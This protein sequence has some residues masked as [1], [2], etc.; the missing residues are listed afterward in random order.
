MKILFVSQYFWPETFKG[1]DIVFE[2]AKKGHEITV[3]TAKPNYPEGNFYEGYGFFK[4]NEEI[5][6][7]VRIIRTPIIPR[8][9][10]NAIHLA[11]NYFSFVFFSFIIFLF[12]L[13]NNYDIILVQQ[14]SPIFS[15][16]PGV[17]MKKKY[18][19]PMVLWVLDLWPESI[20]AASNFKSGILLDWI[21]SIVKKVYSSSD[22]ILISSR[23]FEKSIKEKVKKNIDITYFPNWAEDLF[24]NKNGVLTNISG[25]SSGFN[26]MFA[27]NVGESQDFESILKA[28]KI[29]ETAGVNWIIIG[30]G[31]KTSWV[32][33]EIKEKQLSNVYLLGRHPI[34]MMPS[35]FKKADVMLVSLKDEPIFS[36]TV[37]AKIQAY[38]ASGKIILGMLNGEGAELIKISKCGFSV[39]AGNFIQLA[40]KAIFLASLSSQE[41]KIFEKNALS[42]YNDFFD[43]KM[44]FDQLERI[45]KS[46]KH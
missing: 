2:L 11:L 15:A 35:F 33:Q 12:K 37:P 20:S 41:K 4:P 1:N 32:K 22:H 9:N 46:V 16:L 43:K 29:T 36:L 25:L 28:A 7:G 45:L 10:G 3:L 40:E 34:E 5:V 27:G 13:K 19:I 8:K 31:R 18:K 30:E 39:P 23:N 6:N 14:L 44:L 38:M 42:H 26:I 17:W 24:T 21:N